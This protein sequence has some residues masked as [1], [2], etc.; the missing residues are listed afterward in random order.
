MAKVTITLVRGKSG[1][2]IHVG[3]ESEEGALGYEHERDHRDAVAKLMGL[4]VAQ[5]E[6][7]GIPIVRAKTAAP[8]EVDAPREDEPESARQLSRAMESAA[9]T[10]PNPGRPRRAPRRR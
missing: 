6:A 3:Y 2:E 9:R 1:P 5:L 7:S 10:R 8:T 4:S